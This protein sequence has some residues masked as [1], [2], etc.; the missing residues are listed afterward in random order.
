MALWKGDK[1][2]GTL[3]DTALLGGLFV[4]IS[5]M[6]ARSVIRPYELPVE[7]VTGILG[8]ILFLGMLIRKLHPGVGFHAKAK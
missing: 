4:L 5:D 6:F 8:S 1:I 3:T 7:L 2:Q